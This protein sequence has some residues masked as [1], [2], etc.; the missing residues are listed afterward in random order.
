VTAAGVY[1]LLVTTH[2][3]EHLYTCSLLLP[4]EPL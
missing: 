3:W 2:A 1:V 4:P